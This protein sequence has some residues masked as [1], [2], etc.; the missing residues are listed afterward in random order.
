L[1]GKNMMNNNYILGGDEKMSQG[2]Y[3]CGTCKVHGCLKG[4]TGKMPG[5]CPSLDK[6]GKEIKEM[7]TGEDLFLAKQAAKVES[8]GYCRKTRVE[9]IMDFARKCG[10]KKIG[11]AFCTGLR[12][13][14]AVLNKILT[15]NGFTVSSVICKN[16]S[17]PK[18]FLGLEEQDKVRPGTFEAM[19][20]PIGQAYF[21]NKTKTEL[22]LVLGL[23]VGHDTLFIKH[24]Q[25]PV[26]VLAVKDRVLGHNPMA[27][28]YMAEG[29]YK[30]KLLP[31][32]TGEK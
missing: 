16:C 1:K 18:E 14:M 2:E 25:A 27:A 31:E 4:D 11:V 20:N 32:N 22:N 6:A 29:Y 13:E 7:Y 21:L 23:C 17:I 9:E 19:C 24:S 28:I 10:F 3:F 5:N 30:K 8:E 26:T 12:K 15:V